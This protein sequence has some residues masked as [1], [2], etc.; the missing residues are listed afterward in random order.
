M[1]G[2]PNVGLASEAIDPYNNFD[3]GKIKKLVIH[4]S[5]REDEVEKAAKNIP[6]C[7]A[8]LLPPVCLFFRLIEPTHFFNAVYFVTLENTCH[9]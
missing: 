4:G 6:I 2:G 9:I 5:F 1:P 7:S 3:E 8:F